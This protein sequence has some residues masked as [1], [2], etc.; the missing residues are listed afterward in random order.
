[1]IG[2]TTLKIEQKVLDNTDLQNIS[3]EIGQVTVKDILVSQQSLKVFITQGLSILGT[4]ENSSDN[5][6]FKKI[7]FI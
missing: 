5:E 2:K 4:F 1:M 6:V 7:S 3:N